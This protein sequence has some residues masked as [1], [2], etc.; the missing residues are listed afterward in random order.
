MDTNRLS[1]AEFARLVAVEQHRVLPLAEVAQLTGISQRKLEIECRAGRLE[2]TH[3]G[4]L[5]GMTLA[6]VDLLVASR[7][8]GATE[9]APRITASPHSA[10]VASSRR[11]ANR[12]PRR[13]VA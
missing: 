4:N 2:H 6:Q 12:A 1:V 7:K 9:V 8:A 5:R 3:D 10:A 13:A 11:A